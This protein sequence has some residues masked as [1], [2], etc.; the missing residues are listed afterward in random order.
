[1]PGTLV[2]SVIFNFPVGNIE[3]RDRSWATVDEDSE[4]P[5]LVSAGSESA[6]LPLHL[7]TRTPSGILLGIPLINRRVLH[8]RIIE[9]L[10]L[11]CFTLAPLSL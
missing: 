10:I 5:L 1:M 9:D 3:S 6:P 8:F 7:L 2:H 4:N 11:H